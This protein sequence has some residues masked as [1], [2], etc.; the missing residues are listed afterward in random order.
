MYRSHN[1]L[2]WAI[3]QLAQKNRA[4]ICSL[5]YNVI[6]LICD[7]MQIWLLYFYVYLI[8]VEIT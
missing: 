8:N 1:F 2:F 3:N 7:L 6:N 5:W 4:L